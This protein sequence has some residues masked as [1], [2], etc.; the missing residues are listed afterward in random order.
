MD[1]IKG[2]LPVI[3]EDDLLYRSQRRAFQK[4]SFHHQLPYAECYMDSSV[5]DCLHNLRIRNKQATGVQLPEDV[6]V[7]A[8]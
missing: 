2:S 5:E 4:I 7:K 3:V 6:V 8:H 1:V